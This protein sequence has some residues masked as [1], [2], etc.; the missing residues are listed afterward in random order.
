MNLCEFFFFF[1]DVDVSDD[2]GVLT[3]PL[4]PECSRSL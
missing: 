3:L 4:F 2:Y 1:G